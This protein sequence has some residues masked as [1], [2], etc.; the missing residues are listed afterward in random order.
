MKKLTIGFYIAI[1]C[2]IKIPNSKAESSNTKV[3]KTFLCKAEDRR[4]LIFPNP[5]R[6][7][8][9]RVEL[10][11]ILNLSNVLNNDVFAKIKSINTVNDVTTMLLKQPWAGVGN[12]RSVLLTISE[13]SGQG[14]VVLEDF[15]HGLRSNEYFRNGQ[16]TV[17]LKECRT[18][19]YRFSAATPPWK[20]EKPFDWSRPNE[21]DEV[22]EIF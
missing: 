19:R 1:A 17:S 14:R 13:K 4:I 8:V 16:L 10:K 21:P 20:V 11:K 12:Y 6:L 15:Q 22:G 5:D 2:I 7:G 3:I 9:Q 18:V